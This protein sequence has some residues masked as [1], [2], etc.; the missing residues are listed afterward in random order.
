MKRGVDGA[1]VL[2]IILNRIFEPLVRLV[3]ARG[4]FIPYFAGD[5][6]TAI[7]PK[8]SNIQ[9]WEIILTAQR[10]RDLFR[11]KEVWRTRYGDFKIGV[12][13]GISTG[14]VEWGIVGNRHKSFY[15]RGAGIDQCVQSEVHALEQ[16]I[17][18]DEPFFQA[19]PN[20]TTFFQPKATGF[21][22]LTKEYLPEN[23]KAYTTSQQPLLSKTV[24]EKFLL[25]SVVRFNQQGEFRSVV[26]VFI[27]FKGVEDHDNLNKFVSIVL[28]Q[29]Y[30]FSGYLKEVDFSDKGGVLVG[31]FGAPTSFENNDERAL[32]LAL[33]IETLTQPLQKETNL[34]YRMG[35]TAG[36]AYTGI[37]G[38]T[39]RCQYAAV[40]NRVNLAARLMTYADWGEVLVGR[41]IQ[42]NRNYRFKH[43]G[44]IHYK[45]ILGNVPTYVLQGQLVG[46]NPTYNGEMI[47]RDEE[48]TALETFANQTFKQQV[49]GI[50]YIYGEAGIGK[51]RISHELKNRLQ[52]TNSITFITCQADQILQKPFNPFIY[53]LNYYFKQ[54]PELNKVANR[55]N[56]EKRFQQLLNDI[57][58]IDHPEAKEIYLEISRTRSVLAA[59]IGIHY[60]DSLW[61]QL[62]AKGKYQNILSAIITLFKAECLIQPVFIE[63]EDG[64]WFDD[65]SIE[66]VNELIKQVASYPIFI[67]VTSRYKDDGSKSSILDNVMLGE[68]AAIQYYEVDL[69]LLQPKVLENLA[70]S[71]LGGALDDD[72]LELFERL[73]N[74]NPFYAE[75]I[76]EYFLES[77]LLIQENEKWVLKDNS[78]RLSASINSVLMARIDRLS[79][80]VKETVKAAAVIGREFEVPVLSE[81][82]QNQN[83]FSNTNNGNLKVLLTEQIK[84]AEK[85][86]IWRA[87]NELRYI[88]KHSLLREAVY[89]MQLRT[90][91]RELHASIARAIEKVYAEKLEE[92]YLDLSFHYEHADNEEKTIEFTRKA[93]RIARK[94]FQNKTALQLYDKYINLIKDKIELRPELISAKLRRASVLEMVGDWKK[95]E[96][97]LS[98]ALR[99][100]KDLGDDILSGRVYNSYGYLLL[101]TG[102]YKK[103]KKNL[104]KALL[105]LEASNSDYELVKAYSNL[106]NLN[107]RQ[108]QYKEAEGFFIKSIELSKQYDYNSINAQTVANLG[109]TYMNLGE[110]EQGIQWQKKQLNI[111]KERNDKS[112]MAI[113]DT[114]LGIV[115]F[116]KG[117]YDNAL[118]CYQQGLELAQELGN[119]QLTAIAIGCIGTVYERKGDYANAM[120]NFQKDLEVVEELGDQQGIAITLGLIGQL[121]T[122][123]GEFD[124]AIQYLE[125]QLAICRELSYQ[126]GIAKAVNTLGDIYYYKNQYEISIKYYDLAIDVSRQ[127]NN[128][129]VLGESLVEKGK[130]LLAQ[131]KFEEAIAIQKEALKLSKQL[132]NPNL[133][134]DAKLLGARVASTTGKKEKANKILSTLLEKIDTPK[135]KAAIFYELYQ[136]DKQTIY[137]D[138]ALKLYQKLYDETP[139]F[140]FKQRIQKLILGR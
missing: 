37:V 35:I 69:N 34:Q 124:K 100:A 74:G 12:K 59:Q 94:S 62:D 106:G 83:G 28:T 96:K 137:R 115:Y 91:L 136:I 65:S 119:K 93:A 4:G 110:F 127:I 73:T 30:N 29:F 43:K 126:K 21:R 18:I 48:L 42:K 117:D 6:F 67:L 13:V 125:R 82:M 97:S 52:A 47:G 7:F 46:N 122:V 60:E 131:E 32:E 118:A 101:L 15:F 38:G 55:S 138:N 57:G 50:A 26:T 86:Q 84:T 68:M 78:I 108:G 134:F 129:L 63:L 9:A 121:H 17:I 36:T 140:I 104:E 133:L 85:G 72:F 80:L 111:C 102:K 56:F 95:C 44:D 75:Q 79:D 92:K 103:A 120:H 123:K 64:H 132:G 114:N 139:Q 99:Y 51:S 2:S 22:Q 98:S 135:E 66:L 41:N 112:G 77:D 27:S 23:T 128:R 109:L 49:P 8:S 3:Y 40:G 16:E 33:A 31:F 11:K 39:E 116:E 10:I 113:L 71:R 19:V 5:A 90:R 107:F 87:M 45:G 58:Q 24:A 25:D 130:P 70:Y 54:S 53:F 20:L 76:L 89:E 14:N 61:E 88:F 105:H 81:V 1:E